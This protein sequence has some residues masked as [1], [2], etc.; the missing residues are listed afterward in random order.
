LEAGPRGYRV[1]VIDYDAS[2]QTLYAAK[3]LPP[4]DDPYRDAPDSILLSDPGFH[5]QNVYAIIMRTL[6]AFEF[7]LGRR[8]SWAFDSHQLQVAPHAF[9]LPNAFYSRRDQ[10]LLFGYF[11]MPDGNAFTCLSHDI[12][13][14][15]TTHALLDGLRE[16]YTDPSSVDQLAFHEGFADVIAL[17][18]VFSLENVVRAL[19]NSDSKTSERRLI[20]KKLTTEDALTQSALFGLGEQIGAAMPTSRGDALRRSVKLPENP[21]ILD[22][23]EFEEPHRRGEVFVAAMMKSFV[24]VWVKRLS[25]LGEVERGM[26]QLDRVVEDGAKAAKHLM[27]MAIRALDYCPPTA[28]RFNQ[29]LTAL[30]TADEELQPDDSQYGY[31][32]VLQES[33]A[34]FGIKRE[35]NGW[36]LSGETQNA[37]RYRR[38]HAEALTSEPDEVF[39]FVWENRVALQLHVLAYTK[40]IS[41][42]PCTRLSNE[43]FILR[44]TVAEYIQLASL[45]AVE[46]ATKIGRSMPEGTSEDEQIRLYGGGT[47][48]FDEFGRLKYHA[49]NPVLDVAQNR[50]HLLELWDRGYFD[51]GAV[52]RFSQLH[53]N[54]AT[55]MPLM[56]PK[57][58]TAW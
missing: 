40:V 34:K 28:L 53:L 42:R 4:T 1:H 43:G 45:P 38:T 19:L 48:I 44:E 57:G 41:V 30:L 15:E 24:K 52:N 29:Y 55:S 18:S 31:R 27:T 8:I 50:R 58:E 26:L 35:S 54:R 12:V 36:K 9:A 39:R 14:H 20:P 22:Q 51:D 16:R 23:D 46:L 13:A 21:K 56:A 2:T 47:L 37:L 5:A 6:G 10:A 3:T 49:S 11:S 25:T 33:F 7:A 32:D 17:L